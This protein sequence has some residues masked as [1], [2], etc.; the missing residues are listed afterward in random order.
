MKL[1]PLLYTNEAARTPME[2]IINDVV[3]V[4]IRG[5]TSEA[6]V[7]S[8]GAV[9]L[10]DTAV[11][12]KACRKLFE[13]TNSDDDNSDDDDYSGNRNK[14]KEPKEVSSYNFRGR[15]FLSSVKGYVS[16]KRLAETTESL[17][18][19]STSA[20]VDR[21]GPL[22]YQLVMY[23]I[24]KS[25]KGWL[26][27]DN[28]LTAGSHSSSKVWNGMYANSKAIY[29]KKWVGD[30]YPE[31]VTA[32][33]LTRLTE[34]NDD[35]SSELYDYNQQ[36]YRLN[37][38]ENYALL[39]YHLS[40]EYFLDFCG[41][42]KL[43]PSQ[44]GHFWAYRLRNPTSSVARNMFELSTDLYQAVEKMREEFGVSYQ[45]EEQNND[46][47]KGSGGRP[48]DPYAPVSRGY[49]PEKSKLQD[50]DETPKLYGITPAE[51]DQITQ[52][53]GR[54]FFGMRYH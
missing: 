10:L 33:V 20:G 18:K 7:H 51:F 24:D 34:V 32:G 19:V 2:A 22:T 52:E 49:D 29:E 54:E 9:I 11:F 3:A 53:L 26:R 1:Y 28:S 4:W 39:R 8:D 13:G 42:K 44:F 35:V 48:R 37:R 16:Y 30:F 50:K 40:E 38:D 36:L 15:S 25:N 17:F 45:G 27:S 14:D 5:G 41:E 46:H 23:V 21:Y 12:L 47:R 6:D 43:S 31:S